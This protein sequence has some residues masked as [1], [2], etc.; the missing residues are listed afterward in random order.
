M[1]EDPAF[2]ILLCSMCAVCPTK[3]QEPRGRSAASGASRR[4]AAEEGGARVPAPAGQS[5]LTQP[6]NL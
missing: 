6:A 4:A 5:G 3:I 2:Y 1:E